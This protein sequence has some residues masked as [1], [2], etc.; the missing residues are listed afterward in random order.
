MAARAAAE[1]RAV[2][3][4]GG[5]GSAANDNLSAAGIESLSATQLAIDGEGVV[6]ARGYRNAAGIGGGDGGHGADAWPAGQEGEGGETLW[7]VE[8]RGLPP[9][10]GVCD[11]TGLEALGV[12]EAVASAGGRV[13]I[14]LP[15]SDTQY[16]FAIDGLSFHALVA[17]A[18][19]IAWYE[20]GMTVDGVDLGTDAETQGWSYD[21]APGIL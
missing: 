12:T 21:G 8:V 3:A 1:E 5:H 20:T 6:V 16:D 7:R 15:S 11:I 18:P 13:T 17:D 10:T 4:G 9:V 14:Y 2:F 19:A